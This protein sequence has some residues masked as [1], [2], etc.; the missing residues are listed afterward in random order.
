MV[1]AMM[2]RKLRRNLTDYGPWWEAIHAAAATAPRLK[3]HNNRKEN[4][5]TETPRTRRRRFS[6]KAFQKRI[7]T[8]RIDAGLSFRAAGKKSGV[9]FS[10][11][12]NIEMGRA[13]CGLGV[14]TRLCRAYDTTPNFLL[15]GVE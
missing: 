8:A 15:F 1:A 11:I 9:H 2:T 3:F 5:M 7:R 6:P 14:L 10:T 12:S 4:P 13:L